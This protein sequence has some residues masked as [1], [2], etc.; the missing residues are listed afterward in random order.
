MKNFSRR[1][2]VA[3]WLEEEETEQD[4]DEVGPLEKYGWVRRWGE[5]RGGGIREEVECTKAGS[6][7]D[8]VVSDKWEMLSEEDGGREESKQPFAEGGQSVCNEYSE[9]CS[10]LEDRSTHRTNTHTHARA[11]TDKCVYTIILLH[12]INEA[13]PHEDPDLFRKG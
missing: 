2:S 1:S 10:A 8:G 3:V 12:E 6:L 5:V 7:C 11:H 4:G 9:R 13:I